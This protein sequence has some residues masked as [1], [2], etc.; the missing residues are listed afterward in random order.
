MSLQKQA[1]DIVAARWFKNG[2]EKKYRE[3]KHY[4]EITE[5]NSLDMQ[6]NSEVEEV[7]AELENENNG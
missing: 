5:L 7:L 1:E 4:E 3:A 2:K 6:W